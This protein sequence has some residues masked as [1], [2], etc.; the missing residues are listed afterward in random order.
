MKSSDVVSMLC[1]AGIYT[2]VSL[3]AAGCSGE[4][5]KPPLS[6]DLSHE[7]TTHWTYSGAEGPE[8]WGDLSEDYAVCG[9][10][11]YQSPVNFPTQLA[12]A[13]LGHLVF[14]YTATPGVILDNG[15]TIAVI[16][17]DA[18]ELLVN[19]EAH[20]LLQFHFHAHSEHQV[21]G[22]NYPL[23]M[24]LVHASKNSRLA[25]VGFF[26]EVGTTNEVLEEVFDRMADSSADPLLLEADLDL[27]SLLPE[28]H[29]GWSYNGS[30]TT[31]PC[32]EG[33]NWNVQA[34]PL[35]VSA[36]Q[37]AAF[38]E[39]HDGSYRPVGSNAHLDELL[40]AVP[41]N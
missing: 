1:T 34:K 16:L 17:D 25:V 36:A 23:E 30:L 2:G 14:D 39:L 13:E 7:E 29:V 4:D 27:A 21:D 22:N 6:E 20:A 8:Y 41:P 3:A 19:G 12:P 38:T 28:Q 26:F 37:L 35:S 40:D 32:T 5:S 11:E 24:H 15:H 31:P 10:G 9:S 33:V 18:S